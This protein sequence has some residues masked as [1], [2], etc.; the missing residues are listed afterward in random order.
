[1]Y[2]EI[3]GFVIEVGVA[4]YLLNNAMGLEKWRVIHVSDLTKGMEDEKLKKLVSIVLL[5]KGRAL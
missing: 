5:C 3:H 2:S 1:M 4:V